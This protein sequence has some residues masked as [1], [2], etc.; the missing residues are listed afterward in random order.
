MPESPTAPGWTCSWVNAEELGD[1]SAL[2]ELDGVL[3]P[4]G[5]GVR[6]IE[7]KV[8]AA[9]YA[10]ERGVPYLGIC[11]GMQVAVIEY[12]RNVAGL[13]G[14]NSTE[15]DPYTPHPVIDL[16]PE[17]ID[18]AETGGTMRLGDWPMR[19]TPGTRLAELYAEHLDASG[20]VL[21]RHRHRY[22]VNPAYAERLV[23]AGL[24]VSGI[25][26][27]MAGRGAGLVEAI[28]L[29]E[30][31]FFVG[32]QSHPEFGSRLMRASPPFRGFIEAAVA[33]QKER[34]RERQSTA[35]RA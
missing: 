12:A 14:A 29:A 8:R 18:L 35:A 20:V 19:V 31:P 13:Q 3:V 25:T 1:L 33:Y 21:E 28:E 17:Q 24:C 32:L 27:G 15:F 7:G 26:P 23:A 6:G 2:S 16:M 10:R 9:A 4:G 11:L 30:H 34:L 5:F 22:E